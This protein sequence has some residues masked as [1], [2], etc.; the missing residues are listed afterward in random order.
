MTGDDSDGDPTTLGNTRQSN[1]QISQT[2][3]ALTHAFTCTT[4][5]TIHVHHN[6]DI[7]VR[8]ILVHT[9]KS[10]FHTRSSFTPSTC[11]CILTGVQ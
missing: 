6:Y 1:S 11:T 8:A 5:P 4:M 2:E 3:V 9:C 10:G 7:P